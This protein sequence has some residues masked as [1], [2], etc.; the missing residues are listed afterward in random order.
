MNEDVDKVSPTLGF[1]IKTINYEGYTFLLSY[2]NQADI[3]SSYKLNICI[4]RIYS[5]WNGNY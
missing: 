3:E 1:I 2:S 4:G 5:P